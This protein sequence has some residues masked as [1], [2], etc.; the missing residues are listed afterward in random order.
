[1][2]I[3][4]IRRNLLEMDAKIEEHRQKSIDARKPRGADK[5]K[6]YFILHSEGV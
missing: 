1:M 6:L 4:E 5:S 3:A 2:K